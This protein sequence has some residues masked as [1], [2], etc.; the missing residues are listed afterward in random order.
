M[1]IAA[2]RSL[3]RAHSASPTAAWSSQVWWRAQAAAYIIRPNNHTM[4]KIWRLR[5]NPALHHVW[6]YG[7]PATHLSVPYPLP[8][9]TISMHVRCELEHIPARN[10]TT[11]PTSVI[12]LRMLFLA[13]LTIKP[14]MSLWSGTIRHL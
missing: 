4:A 9:G 1:L 13:F 2:L 11:L 10:P 8:A 5:Q 12:R 3:S 6:Q 14:S 7:R